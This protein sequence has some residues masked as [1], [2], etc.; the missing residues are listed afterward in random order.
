[1][2]KRYV[3]LCGSANLAPWISVGEILRKLET[4]KGE[5]LVKKEIEKQDKKESKK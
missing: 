4:K 2:E 1:M 5:E 3:E